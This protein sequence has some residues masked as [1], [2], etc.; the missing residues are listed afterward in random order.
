MSIL[1]RFMQGGPAEHHNIAPFFGLHPGDTAEG[2]RKQLQELRDEGIYSITV[3]YS[4]KPGSMEKTKFDGDFYAAAKELCSALRE[5][6]MTFWLQDAAPFPTGY[7]S[8]ALEQPENA[9][10]GKLF[11][12]ERHLH[13]T[14]PYPGAVFRIDNLLHSVTGAALRDPGELVK[15]SSRKIIGIAAYRID[16]DNRMEDGSAIDLHDDLQD[17]FLY[18]N[19]PAGHWRIYVLFTTYENHGR[20]SYINLLSRDSVALQIAHVHQPVYEHLRAHL[21]QEWNGFFYDEPEIGNVPEGLR[22]NFEITCGMRQHSANDNIS[23]PWSAEMPQEMESRDPEW[24]IHLPYLYYDGQ[25]QEST[26]RYHYMDAVTSLICRNYNGQVYSWM[27]ERGVPYIGHVLEDENSH[28]RLGCG[29]GHYFRAQYY[30]DMAG[31]DLISAQHM[32]G[33][34]RATSWYGASNGDGAFYHYMLAKLASSEAHLNPLK[35][36]MSFCEVFAVYG[37]MMSPKYRKYLL[38]HLLVNGINHF[39]FGGAETFGLPAGYMRQLAA[40]T[41][42]MC[43]L[44]QNTKPVIRTAVLYH[45]DMEWAG[46]TEYSYVPAGELARHQISYDII[47]ADVFS[48]PERYDAKFEDGLSVNGH[49]YDALI[50]PGCEHIPESVAAFAKRALQA[51]YPVMV[52]D[53]MPT[54]LCGNGRAADMDAATLVSADHLAEEILKVTSPD[55]VIRGDAPWIRTM[56]RMDGNA[57]IWIVHNEAPCGT[58]DLAIETGSSETMC[59]LD[60]LTGE[61]EELGSG[62]ILLHLEQFQLKILFYEK[63]GIRGGG[64]A[65]KAESSADGGRHTSSAGHRGNQAG[66]GR[67]ILIPEDGW[68]ISATREAAGEPERT[69]F[70]SLGDMSAPD[71]LGRDFSGKLLYELR[72]NFSEA[73][74]RHGACVLDLGQVFEC[75]SVCVNGQ[76]AGMR[77]TAPYRFDITELLRT[78]ENRITVEVFNNPVNQRQN[79]VLGLPYQNFNASPYFVQEPAGIL[80]PV[81]LMVYG[82]PG[83]E[84]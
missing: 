58:A 40:Y 50:I 43:H 65:V 82:M 29:C 21:G 53:Y 74:A 47:P 30:Q 37:P 67:E 68:Q 84:S 66:E 5:L 78:G 48:Y 42:R 22:E 57:P 54:E 60:P 46:K 83:Q 34:D 27:K 52:T 17:G 32:P 2:I 39:I 49:S 7:A 77:F 44:L 36:G 4:Q 56:M 20:K 12:E 24:I 73:N 28:S 6:R 79:V 8:G 63:D 72:I 1:D 69:P 64:A 10:K 16:P 13:V 25:G 3:E 41:D 45:A 61:E 59:A 81:K 55:L 51:G 35:N 62:E 75:A 11:I 19:V 23:L 14:G 76:E 9:D 33:C 80:G 15:I 70:S 71:R 18:W 38:N 26:T 31:I